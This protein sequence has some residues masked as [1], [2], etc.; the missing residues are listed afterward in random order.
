MKIVSILFVLLTLSISI[1]LI[2]CNRDPDEVISD[3]IVENIEIY[4]S[5]PETGR[6]QTGQ[7]LFLVVAIVRLAFP[8][9]CS[10]YHETEYPVANSTFYESD[11][12]IW[13]DRDTIEFRMTASEYTGPDMCPAAVHYY[14]KLIVIGYCFPG[15]YRLKVNH[16]EKMFTVNPANVEG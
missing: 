6:I 2:G 12:P 10:S 5:K 3:A 13:Q 14:N 11:I 1:S 15:N 16:S 7:Q 8:D 4:V 9:G